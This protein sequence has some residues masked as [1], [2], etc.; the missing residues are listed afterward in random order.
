MAKLAQ[1]N[2]SLLRSQAT[3]P[4]VLRARFKAGKQFGRFIMLSRIAA[5]W[6]TRPSV[7]FVEASAS[8]SGLSLAQT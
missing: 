3:K 2:L 6:Y 7:N 4:I 8:A 1:T 5:L